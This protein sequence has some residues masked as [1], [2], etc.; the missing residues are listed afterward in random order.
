MAK[1]KTLKDKGEVFYPQTHIEAVVDDNGNTVT[2]LIDEISREIAPLETEVEELGNK[3]AE[4]ENLSGGSA[5]IPLATTENDGLMSAEDKIKLESSCVKTS[6]IEDIFKYTTQVDTYYS[7][8]NG[9]NYTTKA[10]E[11]IP[12]SEYNIKVEVSRPVDSPM[13][14]YCQDEDGNSLGYIGTLEN[15]KSSLQKKILLKVD[16][17][18]IR[19]SQTY[20][21][22]YSIT[23]SVSPTTS[24]LDELKN[25]VKNIEKDIF[26]Y[27]DIKSNRTEI[28]F[29]KSDGTI[30]SS[31]TNYSIDYYEV[32]NVQAYYR[33]STSNLKTEGVFM[34]HF[35]DNNSGYLGHDSVKDS[36]L[37]NYTFNIPTNT[38]YVA[39]NRYTT[40][41][42]ELSTTDTEQIQ[43]T[44]RVATLEKLYDEKSPKKTIV[45]FG[46]SIT[47]MKDNS[48]NSYIDYVADNLNLVAYNA[49]VGGSTMNVPEECVFVRI[50][51]PATTSGDVMIKF[52]NAIKAITFQVEAGDSVETIAQK[53]FNAYEAVDISLAH[54]ISGNEV[55]IRNWSG[56]KIPC[57]EDNLIFNTETGVEIE[58]RKNPYGMFETF[59]NTYTAYHNLDI[60]QMVYGLVTKNWT[61]QRLAAEYL[62]ENNILGFV[63]KITELEKINISDVDIVTVAGGSNNY[64]QPDWGDN[65]STNYTCLAGG[66]NDI[67]RM[68]LSAKKDLKL[69]FLT[70]TPHYYGNNIANWDD[71]QWGGNLV[72][73][74]KVGVTRLLVEKIKEIANHNCVPVFDMYYSMGWNKWNF[75]QFFRE[76]DG[77]HP[78]FGLKWMADKI[79]NYLK[80]LL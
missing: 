61:C 50:T 21:I 25:N 79:T 80:N 20:S 16:K 18:Y 37:E 66:M 38:S 71:T 15:G 59:K 27:K 73:G 57:S 64:R 44:T 63:E 55:C 69:A 58:L 33:A 31:Y 48:G 34:I 8:T 17:F 52:E 23:I 60:P 41:Y 11:S 76:N 46:D 35:Y 74:D 26:L 47:M 24:I 40:G 62:A 51:S 70:P 78:K 75:S 49:G 4:L 32:S 36:Q 45:A 39:I 29:I 3:V 54:Y 6:N 1:I 2:E 9:L 56:F 30:A 43:I 28:G 65:D 19:Y 22:D 7:S 10:F 42:T 53:C 67:I 77:V 13:Y 5:D 68:L 14:I 72:V 12:N